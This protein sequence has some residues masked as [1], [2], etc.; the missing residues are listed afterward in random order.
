MTTDERQNA[1]D[2]LI[3]A[4]VEDTQMLDLSITDENVNL[5]V[6]NLRSFNHNKSADF[7]LSMFDR[8]IM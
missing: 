6:K 5:H 3:K 2:R 8:C 7:M 4:K 1:I